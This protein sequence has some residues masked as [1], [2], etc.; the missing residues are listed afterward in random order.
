MNNRSNTQNKQQTTKNKQQ[1]TKTNKNKQ[2]Q[3]TDRFDSSKFIEFA[4]QGHQCSAKHAHFV[5]DNHGKLKWLSQVKVK[6][7]QTNMNIKIT[8][9]NEYNQTNMNK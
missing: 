5:E 1:T 6:H 3:K 2:K 9:M 4:C 7:K 8:N